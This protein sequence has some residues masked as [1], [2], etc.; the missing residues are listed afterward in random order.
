M[1]RATPNYQS[2]AETSSVSYKDDVPPGYRTNFDALKNLHCKEIWAYTDRAFGV[3]L[4]TAFVLVMEGGHVY[5][6]EGGPSRSPRPQSAFRLTIQELCSRIGLCRRYDMGYMM[7]HIDRLGSIVPRVYCGSIRGDASRESPGTMHF[8]E[9]ID[10]KGMAGVRFFKNIGRRTV[11]IQLLGGKHAQQAFEEIVDMTRKVA[12]AHVAYELVPSAE[13]GTMNCHTFSEMVLNRFQRL[14]LITQSDVKRFYNFSSRFHFGMPGT[15]VG[16]F[17]TGIAWLDRLV[18]PMR[19]SMELLTSLGRYARKEEGVPPPAHCIMPY[20]FM[21]SK[22]L[23]GS[24]SR[25]SLLALAR[26]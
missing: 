22:T 5:V 17:H 12:A 26:R 7:P 25:Q 24:K 15:S 21:P 23:T 16:G 9:V 13:N 3:S 19:S 2:T 8:E 20:S 11:P 18:P 10:G 4:H 6:A 14:G 1:F